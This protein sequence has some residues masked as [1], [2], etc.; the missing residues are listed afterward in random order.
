MV[1]FC[2]E[3]SYIYIYIYNYIYIYIILWCQGS[4]K[5]PSAYY[6]NFQEGASKSTRAIK[7]YAQLKIQDPVTP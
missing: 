6:K 7:M 2:R 1:S 3:Q 4:E 5:G